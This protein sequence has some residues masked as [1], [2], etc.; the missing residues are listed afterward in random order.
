MVAAP[1]LRLRPGQRGLTGARGHAGARVMTSLV[2]LASGVALFATH[3]GLL[4]RM[5]ASWTRIDLGDRNKERDLVARL[6][7]GSTVIAAVGEKVARALFHQKVL[8]GAS[9]GAPAD[10]L[11]LP[12]DVFVGPPDDAAMGER[13]LQRVRSA[14]PSV[15]LWIDE[16]GIAAARDDGERPG[17]PLCAWAWDSA[18][19]RYVI[20]TGDL[21]DCPRAFADADHFADRAVP[22][23]QAAASL[24]E[25][26]CVWTIARPD[27]PISTTAFAPH[28]SCVCAA[29]R[30]L[31]RTVV[32]PTADWPGTCGRH[33]PVWPMETKDA[34]VARV[35]YRRSRSPWSTRPGSLGVALGTG[36]HARAAALGEATERFAM[37]HAPP[38]YV[39]RGPD[40]LG[41][42]PLDT[43]LVDELLYRDEEYGTAGFRFRP[44]DPRATQ[45]WAVASSLVSEE[46]R[47]V[48]A[49]LVGRARLGATSLVDATSN[50]YAAHT[51]RDRAIDGALLELIE[52]DALLLD[53]YAPL[54]EIIR[55]VDGGPERSSTFLVTQDIELPVVIALSTRKDGALCVGS[56]AATTLDAAV[57]RAH[58]ELA[59]A[60]AGS[61]PRRVECALDDPRKRFEPDDHMA[62]LD[63]AAGS[64]LLAAMNAR[65]RPL[66]CSTIRDRW[67][68][69]QPARATILRALAAIGLEPWI[70]DR[71]LPAIFGEG[72]HVVRALVP[73]LVELS[74][75]LPYRRLASRRIT[76]RLAAGAR[77][78]NSPHPI[79]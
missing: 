67:P 5:P 44:Y 78:T 56:A 64:K 10:A 72:W 33:A 42:R 34:T 4:A 30:P 40:A 7:W 18:V 47:A 11:G 71:S 37:L 12:E 27:D 77:L 1:E 8:V 26:R 76:A 58:A 19:A 65:S 13:V 53:A 2:R 68:H 15:V 24:L 54:G 28:P 60:L 63:G 17:C 20:P 74:W 21:A 79:A 52:R 22:V 3:S 57:S 6:A 41:L 36:S 16:R 31:P 61:A 46:Q 14:Q 75:G 25:P 43:A 39:E 51:D 48:P 55:L 66:P 45:D 29:R 70:A 38:T 50:G 62:A 59:V 49:S 73:G 23:A 32:L 69:G 9:H 35:V